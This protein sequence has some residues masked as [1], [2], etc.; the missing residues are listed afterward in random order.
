MQQAC[1]ELTEDLVRSQN[2]DERASFP[3]QGATVILIR[4]FWI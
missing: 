2:C 4:P 1:D 3:C